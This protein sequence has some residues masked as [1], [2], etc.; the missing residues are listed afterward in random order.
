MGD[1]RR[2]R[3]YEARERV[4][5]CKQHKIRP[6]L[7]QGDIQIYPMKENNAFAVHLNG[8]RLSKKEW[9]KLQAD[10]NEAKG[11]VGIDE[12]GNPYTKRKGSAFSTPHRIELD[13]TTGIK[14]VVDVFYFVLDGSDMGY[15]ARMGFYDSED[16]FSDPEGE[17]KIY[18]IPHAWRSCK[19]SF[20]VNRQSKSVPLGQL[21]DQLCRLG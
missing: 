3:E 10:M 1:W 12:Q 4:A 11:I 16:E 9:D 13:K 14:R 17:M 18:E 15:R 2:W 19:I 20:N 5:Y 6:L 8:K 7:N 21:Y